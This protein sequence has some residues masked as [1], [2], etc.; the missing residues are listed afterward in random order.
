M[1]REEERGGV[2][3][4]AEGGGNGDKLGEDEWVGLKAGFEDVSLDLG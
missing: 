3:D 2:E 4:K 1:R